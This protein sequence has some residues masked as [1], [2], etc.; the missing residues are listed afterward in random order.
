MIQAAEVNWEMMDG[1]TAEDLLELPLDRFCNRVLTFM[2]AH[3]SQSEWASFQFRLDLPP[4]GVSPTIG[5]WAEEAMSRG[6]EES[7]GQPR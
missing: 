2:R 7:H 3:M 4:I 5:P 1:T 6:F